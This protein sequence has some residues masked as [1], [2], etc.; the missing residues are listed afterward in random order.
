MSEI[1][2]GNEVQQ[3]TSGVDHEDLVVAQRVP[4]VQL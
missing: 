3:L 1:E 2:A 4:S